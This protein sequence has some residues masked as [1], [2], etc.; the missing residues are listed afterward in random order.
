MMGSFQSIEQYEFSGVLGEFGAAAFNA[1][2]R[3]FQTAAT[4]PSEAVKLLHRV[5]RDRQ[6]TGHPRIVVYAESV[7]MLGI[8]RNHLAISGGCGR[9]FLFDGT[10]NAKARRIMIQSFLTTPRAV[11]FISGAGAVGTTICPGCETMVCLGALPWNY[12]S[13]KQAHGRVHRINQCRPVEIVQLEPSRSTTTIKLL[14]HADK[15]LRLEAAFNDEDFSHFEN[16]ED[17]LWQKRLELTKALQELNE[18]GNYDAGTLGRS[19]EAPLADAIHIPPS[20]FPV[21]GFVETHCEDTTAL[22]P[23]SELSHSQQQLC[24]AKEKARARAADLRSLLDALAGGD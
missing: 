17:V 9:L 2:P 24:A 20:P 18:R 12:S 11:M 3:L 5:V 4:Q 23:A 7:V 22:W 14:G 16:D 1:D 13:V 10:L 15:K 21:E 6:R 8:A 19:I